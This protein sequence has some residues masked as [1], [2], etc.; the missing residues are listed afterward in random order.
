[1]T[2]AELIK[3][4][5]NEE[6]ANFAMEIILNQVNEKFVRTAI[7]IE[8]EKIKTEIAVLEEKNIIYTVNGIKKVNWNPNIDRD[9]QN[10]ANALLYVRNRLVSMLSVRQ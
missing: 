10:A 7:N 6:Q 8:L 2:K 5:G 3:I 9:E 1:M 4:L